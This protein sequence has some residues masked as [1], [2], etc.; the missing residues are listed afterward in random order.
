MKVASCNGSRTPA[1][2]AD[3]AASPAGSESGPDW[4]LAADLCAPCSNAV[5]VSAVFVG[6]VFDVDEIGIFAT[7]AAG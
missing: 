7:L 2:E 3:S 4:L 1:C 6:T 5:F